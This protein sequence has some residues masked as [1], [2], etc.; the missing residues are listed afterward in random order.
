MTVFATRSE[1]GRHSRGNGKGRSGVA[2]FLWRCAMGA[3]AFALA[4]L[5]AIVIAEPA[6][7]H[8]DDPPPCAPGWAWSVDLN[9]CV[10]VLPAANGPGGPGGPGDRA[11]PAGREA[12]VAQ[13]APAGTSQRASVHPGLSG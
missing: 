5:P 10:F 9:Q 3:F 6:I 12:P 11:A 7:S 8:A 13:A 1:P 4:G 2:R